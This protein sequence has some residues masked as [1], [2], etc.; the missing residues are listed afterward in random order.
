MPII[1][2]DAEAEIR[3]CQNCHVCGKYHNTD[4]CPRLSD[5]PRRLAD[6]EKSPKECTWAIPCPAREG[7]HEVP[8]C[9]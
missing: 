1:L 8:T 4:K 3:W 2:H 6:E 7:N 9:E 5:M